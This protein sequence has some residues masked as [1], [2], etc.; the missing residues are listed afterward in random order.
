MKNIKIFIK[1]TLNICVLGGKT[2]RKLIEIYK[3]HQILAHY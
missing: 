1:L 2:L 3:P